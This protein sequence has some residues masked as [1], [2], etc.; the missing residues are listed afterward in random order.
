MRLTINRVE[1]GWI[2]DVGGHSAMAGK[3]YVASTLKDLQLV[4][5]GL[6]SVEEPKDEEAE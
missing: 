3:S 6:Y 5:F 2:V 1:N 4:V